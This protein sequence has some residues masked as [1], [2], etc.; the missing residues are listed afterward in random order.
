MFEGHEPGAVLGKLDAVQDF[1]N[2]VAHGGMRVEKFESAT[3]RKMAGRA[4]LLHDRSN[5]CRV[6]IS[7]HFRF[8]AFVGHSLFGSGAE[9]HEEHGKEDEKQ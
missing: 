1:I 6:G 3:I 8:A 4:M 2:V 9:R 5:V 7:G